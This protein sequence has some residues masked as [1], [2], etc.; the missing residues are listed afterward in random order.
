MN[1]IL[2]YWGN[3]LVGKDFN[4]DFFVN[5]YDFDF[6][7]R[8]VEY[9]IELDFL[10]DKYLEMLEKFWFFDKIYLDWK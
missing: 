7:E 3:F 4:V 1:F 9:I 8:L 10:K 2:V 5:V 6:L